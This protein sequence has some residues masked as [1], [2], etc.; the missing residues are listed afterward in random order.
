MRE[1]R[2][3]RRAETF[4][5]AFLDEG[6]VPVG[7]VGD[8]RGPVLPAGRLPVELT[9]WLLSELLTEGRQGG[10]VVGM[11]VFLLPEMCFPV[12]VLRKP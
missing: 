4:P 2:A 5:G 8:A 12:S 11:V 6:V 1:G 10:W 7:M 3:E 9:S